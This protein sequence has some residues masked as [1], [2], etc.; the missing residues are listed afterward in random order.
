MAERCSTLN[1]Q[2]E[3]GKALLSFEVTAARRRS[4]CCI[5]LSL[6]LPSPSPSHAPWLFPP[7]SARPPR[8]ESDKKDRIVGI[9]QFH[10]SEIWPQ[11]RGS[12]VPS[13]ASPEGSTLVPGH[14]SNWSSHLRSSHQTQRKDALEFGPLVF[15]RPGA[16]LNRA[17]RHSG[18]DWSLG[19]GDRS[20]ASAAYR[21]S[22]ASPS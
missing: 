1:S 9:A 4:R 5:V 12:A 22:G 8:H 20:A 11:K 18:L 21:W 17:R 14:C 7:A 16:R 6:P 13:N 2:H 10:F 15:S 3:A 19:V